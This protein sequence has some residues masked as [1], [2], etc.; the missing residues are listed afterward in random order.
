M[1]LDNPWDRDMPC[2]DPLCN[3]GLAQFLHLNAKGDLQSCGVGGD[4]GFSTIVIQW[5]EDEY[6]AAAHSAVES[7]KPEVLA[8]LWRSA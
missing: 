6:R 7:I 5:S 2:E 4:L 1:P 3:F 8:A